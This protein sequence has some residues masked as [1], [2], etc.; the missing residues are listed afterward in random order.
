MTTNI[1]A[2]AQA[3]YRAMCELPPFAVLAKQLLATDTRAERDALLRDAPAAVQAAALRYAAEP[4]ATR[5]RDRRL[6]WMRED[7]RRV[8]GLRH[9]F[10]SNAADFCSSFGY[11]TDPRLIAKNKLALVPFVLWPKQREMV[12]WMLE[13]WRRGEPGTVVKSRD[14]GASWVA[15]A[16]LCW[17]A[18]FNRNF[19]AGLASA[20]E[21]KLDRSSDPDTLFFKIREFMK[22]IPAEFN[23]GY[24]PDRTSFYLRVTFPET[25]SSI[26]GEA[27]DQA[28]RG[29]RKS[30]YIVD[31][32]AHF[33]RPKLID[34]SLAAT[35]DCRI[36]MSSVNGIG[37][38]FYERAHNPEIPR[39]D[40][41]WRDDPRKDDAWYAQKVATLD[42][43][44]VAQEI[45]ANFA[46][47]VEGVVIP[48]PWV[49]AAVGLLEKLDL[50]S[51]G[52]RFAGL[53]VADRGQDKNAFA[54]RHGI[55]LEHVESWSGA[56]SDIFGTTAKAFRLC[57]ERELKEF[58]FDADGLGAGVRGDARVLNES[59]A[60]AP[61]TV[62]EY[63]GSSSPMFP[64]QKVPRTNRTNEDYYANR[65]AQAWWHLRAR[66]NESWKASRG[67]PY[68]AE[69]IISINPKIPELSRLVA[70]LSQATV[71]ETGTGK[72][73][74]DKVGDGERSPNLADAVVIAFAPRRRGMNISE[75]FVKS[76]ERDVPYPGRDEREAAAAGWADSDEVW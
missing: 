56:N 71:S 10:A 63:R 42:P 7:P 13:R 75:D 68:D 49:Q 64:E 14:V 28:G 61:I 72:L 62:R 58:D 66:F 24:D 76:L 15:S 18:I 11:T 41:T 69:M 32:S 47:A 27:G 37:N 17:L 3:T 4:E 48:S 8:S 2:I 73:Q 19:A 22:H 6:E 45:D 21:A 34:A 43:V 52:K 31:E 70:E 29:G 57:D 36:D 38:S 54:V 67:E 59:R 39:F 25:G 26:T 51:T 33:E 65:K 30:L 35:T 60:K 50:K 12:E 23:G 55:L 53:D 1:D 40:L 46:A 9:Y 16:L 44:I 20:T 5:E 74:I